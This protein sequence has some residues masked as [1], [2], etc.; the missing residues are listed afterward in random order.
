VNVWAG[1]MH[2]KL[3]GPFFL[4]VKDCDLTFV[5]GHAG[6]VSAAPITTCKYP[7]RRVGA[8]TFLLLY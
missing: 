2:N 6:V 1:L 5:L 7:L 4:I 8:T 3:I